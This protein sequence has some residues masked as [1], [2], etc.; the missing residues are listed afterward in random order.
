MLLRQNQL[1][2]ALTGKSHV[3]LYCHQVRNIRV[4][5]V[6]LLCIWGVFP[7][8]FGK[9]VAKAVLPSCGTFS[10]VHY[11]RDFHHLIE[12]KKKSDLQHRLTSTEIK[13]E[14]MTIKDGSWT[15]WL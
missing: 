4:S 12:K 13:I 2:Q 5:K 9:N 11:L 6:C 1:Y 14:T 8:G 7:A 10:L 15:T 3:S